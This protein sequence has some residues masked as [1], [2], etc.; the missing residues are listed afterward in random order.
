[1]I[2]QRDERTRSSMTEQA[3]GAVL[4]DIAQDIVTLTGVAVGAIWSADDDSG[5]L[6]VAAVA[7]A[8]AGSLPLATLSYGMGAVGWI[9][10]QRTALEVADVFK[11][12]RFVGHDWRRSHN[13]TSFCGRPLML[14]DRLFGVLALDSSAPIALTA[15]QH[16]RLADLAARAA[17]VLGRNWRTTE[18]RRQ[19]E[20]LGTV[21]A[22]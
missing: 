21:R 16:D 15:F 3:A 7:G 4:Q 17:E 6:A 5:T 19:Q 13:L 20:E 11:D 14:A 9:A 18:D 12:A 2:D 1:M 22:Q 10:L 8:E